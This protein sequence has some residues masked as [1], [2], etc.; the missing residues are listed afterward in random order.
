MGLAGG[1]QA[2]SGGSPKGEGLV[3]KPNRA[4]FPSHF[5]PALEMDSLVLSL[6][7]PNFAF[8]PLAMP[9]TGP[10][11]TSWTPLPSAASSLASLRDVSLV[12]VTAG[13]L[14]SLLH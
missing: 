13:C 8:F 6:Q 9:G 7:P 1:G 14:E 11:E 4:H 2:A 5:P 10:G 3:G 12:S